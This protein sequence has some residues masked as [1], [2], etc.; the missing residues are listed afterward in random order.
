MNC[1]MAITGSLPV[2][3]YRLPSDYACILI[4]MLFLFMQF[5]CS[6]LLWPFAWVMGTPDED[7]KQV[8]TLIGIKTFTNEF[9]AYRQLAD[10]IDNRNTISSWESR[11]LNHTLAYDPLR[12][13][14]QVTNG[15]FTA[16][17]EQITVS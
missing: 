6:Y 15:T 8:A 12:N 14:H 1:S 3:L 7:C 5:I 4:L 17:L 16:C 9:I 13:C 11:G 10:L 2:D